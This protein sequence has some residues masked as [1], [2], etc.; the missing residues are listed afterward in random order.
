[1]ARLG[2]LVVQYFM[3]AGR[4][5]EAKAR[6]VPYHPAGARGARP[7]D[8]VLREAV[9]RTARRFGLTEGEVLAILDQE[10]AW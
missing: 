8:Q 3:R 7:E 1:M 6:R 4:A 5:A 2:R 10:R 9:A